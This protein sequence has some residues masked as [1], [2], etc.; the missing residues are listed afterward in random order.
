MFSR[1]QF[2]ETSGIMDQETYRQ[3]SDVEKIFGADVQKPT[4]NAISTATKEV[5]SRKRQCIGLP[6]IIHVKRILFNQII[7]EMTSIVTG[8]TNFLISL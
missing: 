7:K 3:M 1:D 2:M 6:C 4:N 8:V 5:I